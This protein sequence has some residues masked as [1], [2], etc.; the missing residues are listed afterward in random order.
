MVKH[1]RKVRAGPVDPSSG[2][3]WTNPPKTYRP[4]PTSWTRPD[5]VP[6]LP[7]CMHPLPHQDAPA[8]RRW[9]PLDPPG[10][11]A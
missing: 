4:D 9:S 8:A 3:I 1:R 7:T 11:F 2:H 6:D 5:P 10:L